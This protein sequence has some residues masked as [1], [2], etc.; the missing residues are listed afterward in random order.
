MVFSYCLSFVLGG[1]AATI[2]GAIFVFWGVFTPQLQAVQRNWEFL[3]GRELA[4][5]YDDEMGGGAVATALTM[6]VLGLSAPGTFW[7][8]VF[9]TFVGCLRCEICLCTARR[10]I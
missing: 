7:C 2:L 5:R 9:R 10:R 4:D 8:L 3:G 6:L 1:F